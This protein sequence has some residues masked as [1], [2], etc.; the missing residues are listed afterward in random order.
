MN[1]KA[2]K[3][4]CQENDELISNVV[5]KFLIYYAAA[6]NK[7]EVEMER[8]FDAYDHVTLSCQE[9]WIKRS[10]AQFLAHRI[11]KKRRSDKKLFKTSC[12]E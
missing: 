6:H 4:A 2:I 1:Y 3:L 12:I 8:K 11:F 7:L 5:D 10:K 9:E